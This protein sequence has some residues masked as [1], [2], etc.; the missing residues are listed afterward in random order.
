[1]TS[2]ANEIVTDEKESPASATPQVVS[3]DEQAEI[4]KE[5]YN[6]SDDSSNTIDLDGTVQED[7]TP[8]ST[9]NDK[10]DPI[11][12]IVP[13][14]SF[15]DIQFKLHER[16]ETEHV[17]VI[18]PIVKGVPHIHSIELGYS[19]LFINTPSSK[20]IAQ[21]V[22]KFTMCF[23]SSG[24]RKIDF[25]NQTEEYINDV[26]KIKKE[27]NQMV[28]QLL[29]KITTNEKL[30]TVASYY[31][32]I[33]RPDDTDFYEP[34]DGDEVIYVQRF[35]KHLHKKINVYATT[36]KTFFIYDNGYYRID[37]G[38]TVTSKNICD[39]LAN[40]YRSRVE[41]EVKSYLKSVYV[42]D[43]DLLYK[44][45]NVINCINGYID[46]NNP[47]EL[48]S[49][50]PELMT[51]FRLNANFKPGLKCPNI[52][53]FMIDIL[54]NEKDR[55]IVLDFLA[56]CLIPN[57]DMQK[58]LFLLGPGGNGKSKLLEL[59]D[60]LIGEGAY[61]AI[62]LQSLEKNKF[63][64]SNLEG[65]LINACPDLP[66]EVI[67]DSSVFKSIVGG[68]MIAGEKKFKDI[69]KFRCM[70]RLIF[71]MNACPAVPETTDDGYFRRI[72][73]IHFRENFKTNGK[74]D[75]EIMKKLTTPE[76][77]SG[78]LNLLIER[79]IVLRANKWKIPNLP[80][81][82]ETRKDY[83][84]NSF[85]TM[86]FVDECLKHS[87]TDRISLNIMYAVYKT[88]AV[89]N[90]IRPEKERNFNKQ[91]KSLNYEAKQQHD[92][93]YRGSTCWMDVKF[94]NVENPRVD[95]P[96]ES[97][98]DPAEA[99]KMSTEAM[100]DYNQ[101]KEKRYIDAKKQ[102]SEVKSK[103]GILI[104]QFYREKCPDYDFRDSGVKYV[105]E[106][107]DEFDDWL[108]EKGHLTLFEA[109]KEFLTSYAIPQCEYWNKNHRFDMVIKDTPEV[110][111]YYDEYLEESLQNR[112]NV[113]G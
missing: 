112:T 43:R 16:I 51:G 85:S 83:T 77:L 40:D 108:T 110:L 72:I 97:I 91:M 17:F 82:E 57:V 66:K 102:W 87:I 32:K 63:A 18:T 61:S 11:D 113:H 10:P 37:D 100:E 6:T 71:S 95:N 111:K 42:I 52:T 106:H 90:G 74:D 27:V 20:K 29:G 31:N 80:T 99:K 23:S 59:F 4:D 9:D 54:P 53:R 73:L 89:A 50:T 69:F 56:Y 5:V 41:R 49:H 94:K 2:I 96:A 62:S 103:Q 19:D 65:K 30:K 21:M 68:D 75:P 28:I 88:W 104:R 33:V 38:E 1:M 39:I 84:E 44:N 86:A 109:P 12:V 98:Y 24:L 25:Y 67:Y 70:A 55:N 34:R 64:V 107:E 36:N 101:R 7:A 14:G 92:G 22:E 78:F 105:T 48:L 60:M 45:E 3:I 15:P 13:S 58:A 35:A 8:E 79:L 81:T 46:L 93:V 47:T 76:E 26:K